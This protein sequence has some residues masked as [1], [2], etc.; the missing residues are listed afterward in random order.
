ME[1]GRYM[2]C[3]ITFADLTHTGNGL[4]ADVMPLGVGFVA[5]YAKKVFGEKIEVNIQKFPEKFNAQLA[6]EIPPVVCFGFYSW[7]ARLS[8]AFAQYIKK[9]NP[10]TVV[11]F[12]G[13]NFPLPQDERKEFLE[14]HPQIDFYFKWDGEQAFAKFLQDL[15]DAKMDYQSLKQKRHLGDNLCYLVDGEYIEG[16]NARVLDLMDVPSPYTM[17]L[18]DEFFDT[19]LMPSIE[20]TRGCPY[21]CTFCNDG[22]VLRSKV[23]RKS[24]DYIDEELS[25]IVEHNPHSRQLAIADLNFGMYAWDIQTAQTLN[26]LKKKSTWPD[27]IQCSIGKSNTDRILEV[28]NIINEGDKGIIKLASSLQSTDTNVLKLIKR[29]NLPFQKIVDMRHGKNEKSNSKNLQ[30]YTELIIPLPGET[31]EVHYKTLEDV[32]D[33]LMFNNIDVHQL[34]MLPG[35]D[36]AKRDQ[37][38]LYQLDVRYRAFV[39]CTGVYDIGDQK[40]PIVE[41][42]EIVVATKDMPLDDYV[43]CRKMTLLIKLFIDNNPFKEVFNLVRKMDLSIFKVLRFILENDCYQNQALKDV[44]NNYITMTKQKLFESEEDI[45]RVSS[46]PANMEKF[47]TTGEYGIN[48]TLA[49]RALAYWNGQ[50]DLVAV[51]QAALE[52]YFQSEGKLSPLIKS[53]I[54]EALTFSSMRS[55]RYE[56]R[57]QIRTHKFNFDFVQ[58]EKKNFEV[59][60][61]EVAQPITAKFFHSQEDLDVIEAQADRWGKLKTAHEYGKF[62]QKTNALRTRRK[63]Q[64][65]V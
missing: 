6:E 8:L 59:L 14:K 47:N 19:L 4:N 13:P 37:R 28:T 55:F 23:F 49:C 43:E 60:P 27:R 9:A 39:G 25:Y 54:Q 3:K 57:H 24:D 20:T 48:E 35:S 18:M 11:V 1:K 50:K 21:S 30:N 32:I 41:I 46:D 33:L 64:L 40:V 12:G 58:A 5:A 44:L 63:V 17:G 42:E 16:P 31:K 62:I 10:K 26:R 51:L 15:F 36:M 22:S 65:V 2:T 45:I 34:T 56:E 53:Y 29:K 38:K 7:N 52:D 61:E